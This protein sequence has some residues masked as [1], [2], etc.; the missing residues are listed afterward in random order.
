MRFRT[1]ALAL[2]T[3][4]AVSAAAIVFATPER[5]RT[6]VTSRI[7]I[8]SGGTSIDGFRIGT[9]SIGASETTGTVTLTGTTTSSKVVA[10]VNSGNS[11]NRT[12]TAAPGTDSVLITLSGTA[13]AT[14][15]L[16]VYSIN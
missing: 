7:V 11:S 15:S 16:T 5:I 3:V 10:T 1:F 4:A 13:G 6:I 8:G 9:V 12:F 14:T 2:L